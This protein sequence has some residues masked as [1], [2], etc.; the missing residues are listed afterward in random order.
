MSRRWFNQ[1]FGD[2]AIGG[3]T[4][5]P[6]QYPSKPFW[7]AALTED[8]ETIRSYIMECFRAYYDT[9]TD[10]FQRMRLNLCV[11]S[12]IEFFPREIRVDAVEGLAPSLIGSTPKISSNHVQRLVNE[13]VTAILT[14][15]S[16]IAVVPVGTDWQHTVQADVVKAHLDH[17]DRILQKDRNREVLH[18][19]ARIFGEA[20]R[21][22]FYNKDKGPLDPVFEKRKRMGKKV[23]IE[24]TDGQ[25]YDFNRVIYQGDVDETLPFPWDVGLEP[26][27]CPSEVQWC[28]IRKMVPVDEL[29]ADYPDL[30][31]QILPTNWATEFSTEFMQVEPSRD[32][33]LVVEWFHRSTPYLPDGAY[34]KV[35]PDLTLESGPN[36]LPHNCTS[37]FGNLPVERITDMDIDGMLHGVSRINNILQLQNQHENTL[38]LRGRNI[39]LSAHPKWM[40]PKGACN[41]NRLSNQVTVVQYAG[42]VEP[43]LVTYSSVPND[44]VQYQEAIRS[45]MNDTYGSNPMLRGEPPPG[46]IANA[47]LQFLDTRAQEAMSLP[48]AKAD[49]FEINTYNKRLAVISAN[50][51]EDDERTFQV[52]GKDQKW[53]VKHF[54][55]KALR[56]KYMIVLNISSD[57]PK[58]KDALMQTVFQMSQIW[59]QLFPGEAVAEMFRLGHAQKYLSAGASSWQAAE[60]EN[61]T[62]SMGEKVPEPVPYEDLITHWKSHWKQ[63]THPA[64]QGWGKKE[65]EALLTHTLVTEFIMLEKSKTNTIFAAKLQE[66]VVWPLLLPLP[67]DMGQAQ[68]P[69]PGM[70]AAALEAPED[71]AAGGSA[72]QRAPNAGLSQQRFQ[73]GQFGQSVKPVM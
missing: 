37:E 68:G 2:L 34:Y 14:S 56:G 12:G 19:R 44:V 41:I 69:S 11:Y 43:K 64:F 7:T 70:P 48:Q 3:S 30:A 63:L 4:Y 51:T 52:V 60:Q 6:S 9:N 13:Q 39:F 35:T 33:A 27:T 53:Q 16:D 59:P 42:P 22:I 49:L 45:E 28:F 38:T 46:V 24:G 61:Y 58:R 67:P 54:D 47:A 23:Q 72:P 29:K 18:R 10:R 17:L 32:K 65:Q 40:M 73:N 26:K 36:P 8:E 55:V 5:A 20:Y 62:A 71:P 15:P 57:L 1:L 31:D 25:L 66:L 21:Y 50:Y